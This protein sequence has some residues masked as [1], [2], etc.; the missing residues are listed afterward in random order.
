MRTLAAF[1]IAPYAAKDFDIMNY[2]PI[3]GDAELK[4]MAERNK[5]QIL[6]QKLRKNKLEQQQQ[7]ADGS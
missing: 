5:R 1:S 4:G 2:W 6:L 3:V 7:K